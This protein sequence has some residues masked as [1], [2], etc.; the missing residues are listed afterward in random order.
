MHLM[1]LDL[2]HY[3]RAEERLD[4]KRKCQRMK[5]LA[6]E[7]AHMQAEIGRNAFDFVIKIG[8]T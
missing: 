2:L 8:N 3:V 5:M 4:E 7:I 6:I 1:Y